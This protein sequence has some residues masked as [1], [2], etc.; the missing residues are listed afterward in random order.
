[1][2]IKTI[3]EILQIKPLLAY[4][5]NQFHMMDVPALEIAECLKFEE[6]DDELDNFY[7]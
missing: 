5:I 7:I 2:G 3:S 4:E 1:M 6:G